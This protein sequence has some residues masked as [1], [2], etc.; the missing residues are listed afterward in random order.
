LSYDFYKGFGVEARYHLGL[1]E[2]DERPG[3]YLASYTDSDLGKLSFA[4]LNLYYKF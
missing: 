2:V 4:T 3:Y 1:T